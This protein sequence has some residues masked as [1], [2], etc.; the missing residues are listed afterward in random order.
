MLSTEQH[1]TSK[2]SAHSCLC[3]VCGCRTVADSIFTF[4]L[5]WNSGHKMHTCSEFAGCWLKK[6]FLQN[7]KWTW[8]MTQLFGPTSNS[9]AKMVIPAAET[10]TDYINHL[11]ILSAFQT[12]TTETGWTKSVKGQYCQRLVH[13]ALSHFSLLY[14]FELYSLSVLS[15][16]WEKGLK[17]KQIAG[18]KILFG[19]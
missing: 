8:F 5:F 2:L 10:E 12:Q 18:I 3:K 7:H 4:V 15:C 17:G 13:A 6:I 9:W 19:L 14:N 11:S 1:R 16:K